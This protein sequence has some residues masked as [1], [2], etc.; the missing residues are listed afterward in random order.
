MSSSL[1]MTVTELYLVGLL[2]IHAVPCL[3][4]RIAGLWRQGLFV[5]GAAFAAR[6]IRSLI[7]KR[8]RLS[9]VVTS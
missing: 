3:V 2:I 9:G 6:L 1:R 8:N 7:K 5:G 4:W